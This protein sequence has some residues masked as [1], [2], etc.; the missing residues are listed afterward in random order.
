MTDK[1]YDRF[2]LEAEIMNVWNTKDDLESITSRMMDDP[3]PMSEDDIANVL[4]GL[5]ELHDIRC[6]KLFN[7]FETMVRERK[8][9]EMEKMT[10]GLG[11]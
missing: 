3:D 6:K 9:T 5:S 4:I 8:F 7:V 11:L 10:P 1:K 2:N